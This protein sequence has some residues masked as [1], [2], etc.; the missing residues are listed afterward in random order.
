MP[1]PYGNDSVDFSAAD[2]ITAPYDRSA[3][4]PNPAFDFL[5]GF[6][7]RKLKDLFKW[8]E[9]LAYNSAHIYAAQKKFGELVVT[10]IEYNSP[11]QA[12]R[13]KWKHLYEK[14]LKIKGALMMALLDRGIYG[15]HFTSIYQPFV[16]YL[17]CPDCQYLV[18]IE[19][20][21]YKFELKKLAFKYL[22]PENHLT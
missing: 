11:N 8:C 22:C 17:K 19:H 13:T 6:V 4:H 21:N 20:I 16:R 10:E 9:Y 5:T 3:S 1:S 7:P 15:N 18:N 14:Q 2:A 12:L